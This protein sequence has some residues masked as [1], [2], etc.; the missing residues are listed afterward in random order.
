MNQKKQIIYFLVWLVTSQ[1]LSAAVLPNTIVILV[2]DIGY[3][4]FAGLLNNFG[5]TENIYPACSEL[6]SQ[7]SSEM[8][9]LVE[10]GRNR[11]IEAGLS[12]AELGNISYD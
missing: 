2:K 8:N 6:V 4:D 5:E 12:Q 1:T 9:A 3:G 7:L 11:I 10:E